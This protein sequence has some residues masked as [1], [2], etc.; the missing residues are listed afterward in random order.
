MTAQRSN[1]N[2]VWCNLQTNIY[3]YISWFYN[4]LLINMLFCFP[5]NFILHHLGKAHFRYS[6]LGNSDKFIYMY[7]YVYMYPYI[8]WVFTSVINMLSC[9]L[10]NINLFNY[11]VPLFHC[12]VFCFYFLLYYINFK[13]YFFQVLCVIEWLQWNKY[14]HINVFR[15]EDSI[16][17]WLIIVFVRTSML[18]G[19]E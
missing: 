2:T 18:N 15:A 17:I 4:V 7:T 9:L 3:I 13:I 6:T 19:L 1:S 10:L 5:S 12:Y 8:S 16:S 14:I 11:L